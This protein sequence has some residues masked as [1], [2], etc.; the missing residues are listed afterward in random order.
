MNIED[1]KKEIHKY[2]DIADEHFLKIVH[3]LIENEQI[4]NAADNFSSVTE[5]A[6]KKAKETL[7]SVKDGLSKNLKDFEDK[8]ESWKKQ[9]GI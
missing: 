1:I 9:Q 4:K 2:V 6:V 5:E 3:G 7:S 8:F